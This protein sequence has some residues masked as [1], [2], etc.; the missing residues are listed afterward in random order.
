MGGALDDYFEKKINRTLEDLMSEETIDEEG[1]AFI[2]MYKEGIEVAKKL[3]DDSITE[4][5]KALLILELESIQL[6]MLD[7]SLQDRRKRV[8][9]ED[10]PKRLEEIGL[11]NA[12]EKWNEDLTNDGFVMDDVVEEELM[13]LK[14]LS[15]RYFGHFEVQGTEQDDEFVL[16]A[17]ITEDGIRFRYWNSVFSLMYLGYFDDLE[18]LRNREGLKIIKSFLDKQ[19]EF[20]GDYR[21]R[22]EVCRDGYF[23]MRFDNDFSYYD[24]R[25]IFIKLAVLLD[26]EL[27][28]RYPFENVRAYEKYNQIIL[29]ET[30]EDFN[31]FEVHEL[32]P[33]HGIRHHDSLY[34]D[35]LLQIIIM[36]SYGISRERV[37]QTFS[38]LAAS[39]LECKRKEKA[40]GEQCEAKPDSRPYAVEED[41]KAYSEEEYIAHLIEQ[42]REMSTEEFE[43]YKDM[44]F[45]L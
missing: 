15:Y 4:S 18:P 36:S 43:K 35:R 19:R 40:R 39:L 17:K 42:I 41:G 32:I 3:Q 29:S 2:E 1:Q 20:I 30:I 34:Y 12:Y 37:M 24:I 44:L 9:P 8:S 23:Q 26:K 6:K 27:R 14:T 31:S 13:K 28:R 21:E 25:G 11:L 45:D 38:E 22:M 10:L 7:Y 16:S 33:Y 5:E